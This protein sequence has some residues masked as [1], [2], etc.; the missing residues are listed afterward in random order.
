LIA[1]GKVKLAAKGF[2][3]VFLLC[4]SSLAT[5]Q[6]TTNQLWPE[7]DYW[8][9]FPDSWRLLLFGTVSRARETPFLDGALAGYIDNTIQ[10]NSI[11][12][13]SSVIL[14]TGYMRVVTLTDTD[15][16]THEN[17]LNLDAIPRVYLATDLLM[18]VR[19]RAELRWIEGD[20]STRYRPRLRVEYPVIL[21][22]RRFT[23]YLQ[24]EGYYDTRY[25]AWT[26]NTITGGVEIVLSYLFMLDVNFTR[27]TDVRDG[28]IS[29]VNAIGLGLNIYQ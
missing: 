21:E 5:A 8:I 10:T 12:E 29:H 2:L 11:A 16:R 22:G 20:F 28:S 17:R 14:R 25:D 15:E 13:G 26:R 23:P 19:L 27:Q 9:Y 3:L 1:R 6:N 4:C 18:S 7:I 24:G